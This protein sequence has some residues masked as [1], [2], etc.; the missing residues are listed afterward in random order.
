MS[1][2][3]SRLKCGRAA[4]L[5]KPRN[6]EGCC[7]LHH[8]VGADRRN[9]GRDFGRHRI[10]GHPPRN[11]FHPIFRRI[12][13]TDWIERI[14]GRVTT[15]YGSPDQILTPCGEHS[16]RRPATARRRPT[17]G[18]ECF[19]RDRGRQRFRLSLAFFLIEAVPLPAD[20]AQA[21]IEID[22]DPKSLAKLK[23]IIP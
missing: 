9:Q 7:T 2:S 3:G 5:Q 16:R 6:S 18:M 23:R 17:Q 20:L 10:L 15:L 21:S 22:D 8:H 13:E 11:R 19:V 4:N 1:E 12:F 14:D